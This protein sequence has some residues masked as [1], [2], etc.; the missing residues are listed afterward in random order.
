METPLKNLIMLLSDSTPSSYQFFRIFKLLVDRIESIKLP[1]NHYRQNIMLCQ[2]ELYDFSFLHIKEQSL[3]EIKMFRLQIL[4]D[5]K[6]ESFNEGTLLY[7]PHNKLF[8]NKLRKRN[9]PS[10]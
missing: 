3:K 10:Q 4:P 6:T 7:F 8:I 9:T 2:K 5:T 1:P